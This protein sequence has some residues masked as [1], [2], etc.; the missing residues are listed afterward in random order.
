MIGESGKI[1]Y[2]AIFDQFYKNGHEDWFVEIEE[3][4]TPEQRA[5]R[6]EMMEQWRKRQEEAKK[7]AAEGIQAG[8]GEE[9]RRPPRRP[10]RTPEEESKRLE[11]ALDGIS[12]S[13][14]YLK[15]SKFVK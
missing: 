2:K 7:Q 1:D 15:A 11:T 5:E 8:Q 6:M 3:Y 10:E 12:Q 13:A 9:Q 4:M 14:A